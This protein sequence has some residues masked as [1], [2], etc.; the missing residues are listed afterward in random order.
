MLSHPRRP[1]ATQ[2]ESH[3]A[4]RLCR[5]FSVFL[6]SLSVSVSLCLSVSVCLS[7]SL[8][9]SL[10]VSVSVSV[11]LSLTLSLCLPSCLLACLR[12]CL[13][14]CVPAC[15]PAFLLAFRFVYWEILLFA[16][17]LNVSLEEQRAY[18]LCHVSQ[19]HHYT[20]DEGRKS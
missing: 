12:A 6:G 7:L 3:S 13:R 9:L 14:A 5:I 16:V 19:L 15:L 10:S 11:S 1:P 2:V 17:V 20:N 18:S 8:S 4:F